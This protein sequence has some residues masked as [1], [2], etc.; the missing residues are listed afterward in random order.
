MRLMRT[1]IVLVLT[2]AM[3]SWA[4][5]TGDRVKQ[6]QRD[7]GLLHEA[8]QRIDTNL[9]SFKTSVDERLIELRILV[10]Q[11]AE[12]AAKTSVA[13]NNV[14]TQIGNRL[15][16]QVGTPVAGL[17]TKVDALADEFRFVRENI[18][19]LNTKLGRL[20]TKIVDI[21]S[22]VKTMQAPPPPPPGS[23]TASSAPPPGVSAE[24]LY[25]DA[26]R[27]KLAGNDD[28]ALQQFEDFVRWFPSTGNACDAQFHIGDIYYKKGDFEKALTAF[29]L[30]LEKAPS[31]CGRIAEAHFQKGRTLVKLG[32]KTAAAEEFRELKEKFPTPIWTQR[33]NGELK[34]LGMSTTVPRGTR[35]K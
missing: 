34:A 28:L 24:S 10:S 2:L 5:S 18:A 20:E 16:Q 7:I 31:D 15:A 4:Q 29:D 26:N 1:L 9:A 25:R 11:A 8:I 13:V 27:D 3:A 6:L 19:D 33:A 30:L 17:N 32:Q 14:E 35:R 12:S 21:D 23:G 22:A